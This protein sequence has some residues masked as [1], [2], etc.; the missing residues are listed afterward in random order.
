MMN[1]FVRREGLVLRETF[2]VAS[3]PI[4]QTETVLW[5][6]LLNPSV[7]EIA[8]ISQHFTLDIPNK[9]ER[10]EIEES[11]RYWEDSENITIN[12]YFLMAHSKDGWDIYRT[13]QNETVTF[14]CHKNILF[15][16]RYKEF[17]TFDEIQNRVLASPKKF[18]DGF[19]VLGKIFEYRIELD[20]DLLEKA[21]K[22]MRDLRSGVF[23]QRYQYEELLARLA[24][25]QEFHLRLRD[26]LFDKRRAIMSLLKSPKGDADL[27]KDLTIVSKD[28]NSLVEFTNV[29]MNGLDNIQNLFSSQITIEQNKIIKFFTVVTVAFMPPTLVGTIYGMNFENMPELKWEYGYWIALVTMLISIAAPLLYFK[30]KK[31]L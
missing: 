18:L 2:S 12:T 17:R 26:S 20:A 22:D 8:Y 7:A 11:S 14:L 25:L 4:Q 10:E 9:E 23:G 21:A 29:N 5:I 16:I 19:D 27:K 1:V 28:L 13:L 3:A 31:W 6:D 15:T 30:A 24:E